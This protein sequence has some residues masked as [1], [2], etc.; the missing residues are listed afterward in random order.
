MNYI[1]WE[2]VY[3]KVEPQE[4]NCQVIEQQDV[5]WSQIH[6]CSEGRDKHIDYLVAE[7]HYRSNVHKVNAEG[8][9]DQWAWN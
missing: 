4:H 5:K 8:I 6:G 9:E 2:P 3:A 1:D 7:H